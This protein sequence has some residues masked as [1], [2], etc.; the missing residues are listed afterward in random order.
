MFYTFGVVE[1][2]LLR[3]HN[4]FYWMFVVPPPEGY[5]KIIFACIRNLAGDNSCMAIST[6]F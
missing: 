1:T 6:D 5:D 2:P 4:I 3:A